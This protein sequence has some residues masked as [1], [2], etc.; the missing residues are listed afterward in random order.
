ML[1]QTI[2][3]PIFV[4]AIV[5]LVTNSAFSQSAAV[6]K[7]DSLDKKRAQNVYIEIL[8]TGLIFSA[9]Y[10]TR[11][12]NKQ[13]GLG[14][15]IGV[16]G[17]SIEAS[18]ILTVPVQ[19]NYLIGTNN[20]FF[21]VG[22]GFTYVN[23]VGSDLIFFK[24]N[25]NSDKINTKTIIGNLTFGYR[26]QPNDGGFNFRIGIDPLFNSNNFDSRWFGL[27]CGYTF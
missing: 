27:S 8:G 14:A 12:A 3:K 25:N 2:F 22:L 13:D 15:R 11:F 5:L 1:N 16:G 10:D 24:A 9:N 18:S 7:A 17:Y 23:F 6:A 26:Y 4:L 20:K 21:E 19:I